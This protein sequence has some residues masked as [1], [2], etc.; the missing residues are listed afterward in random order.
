[1]TPDLCSQMV[2]S[3]ALCYASACSNLYQERQARECWVCT[4]C[5][6]QQRFCYLLL[7]VNSNI[8]TVP[9]VLQLTTTKLASPNMI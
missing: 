1:M 8:N 6:F 5:V 4:A 2:S 7:Q 3:E 9:M